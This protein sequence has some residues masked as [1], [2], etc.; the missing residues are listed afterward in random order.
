VYS[1]F[2]DT[3]RLSTYYEH[4]SAS[5]SVVSQ[6]R[7]ACPG[8][9]GRY[10]QEILLLPRTPLNCSAL[11]PNSL[12]A[13]QCAKRPIEHKVRQLARFFSRLSGVRGGF[14]GRTGE[15]LRSPEKAD[16]GNRLA[17]NALVN[18]I[19]EADGRDDRQAAGE[20]ATS[21]FWTLPAVS[22]AIDLLLPF[23]FRWIPWRAAF[24]VLNGHIRDKSVLVGA[25]DRIQDVE[26]QAQGKDKQSQGAGEMQF[27]CRYIVGHGEQRNSVVGAC[28]CNSG[29]RRPTCLNYRDVRYPRDGQHRKRP[30]SSRYSV[31]L[32]ASRA[33]RSPLDEHERGRVQRP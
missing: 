19:A 2:R 27:P 20:Y 21:A 9:G 10:S 1:V 28:R 22:A 7:S 32:A 30:L 31:L 17:G 26:R 33:V 13:R 24:R 6:S 8:C 4:S 15:R 11:W 25:V 23:T 18:V 16:C 29:P 14:S 12:A 3:G 5:V